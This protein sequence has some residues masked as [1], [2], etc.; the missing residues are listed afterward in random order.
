MEKTILTWLNDI[1]KKACLTTEWF[2]RLVAWAWSG[3]TK[4]LISRYLYITQELW[5]NPGNILC[6]TFTNKAANEMKNR[7]RK[8]LWE[9]TSNSLI[10]TYHGFGVRF[11]REEIHK[12]NY[13]K[14]FKILD[15]EDQKAILREVFKELDIEYKNYTF[16]MVLNEIR[17]IK[18]MPTFSIT[19]DYIKNFWINEK[20]DYT[21]SISKGIASKEFPITVINDI[22]N[23]YFVKQKK[24]FALDFDDLLLFSLYILWTDNITREKRSKKLNYIMIDEYQDSN[25]HDNLLID[26]LSEY[27]KNIFVVGDPD[28]T[29]YEWRGASVW[30]INNFHKSHIKTETIIM[31]ENYRSTKT[32]LS[33]ANS[34]IKNNKNRIEKDLFTKNKE[35]EKIIYFHW[36]DDSDEANRISQKIKELYSNWVK[37]NDIAV[38]FRASASSRKIEQ[39]FIKNN[40]SYIIYGWI[41]FFERKEI[42]DIIAYLQLLM[43]QDDDIAFRRIINYPGRLIWEKRLEYIEQLAN[44]EKTSLYRVL[45]KYWGSKK[46]EGTWSISF[47]DT[48]EY[49]RKQIETIKISDLLDKLLQETWIMKI[50]RQDWDEDRLENVEELISSIIAMEENYWE[51]LALSQYLQDIALYTNLDK[52]EKKGSVK[53]MTIHQAKWL[54]FPYVFICDL[55][56]W[57]FP[58]KRSIEEAKEEWL[59]EERRLMYVATTRAKEQLFLTNSEWFHHSSWD[60][61]PSRFLHEIDNPLLIIEWEKE[62]A[63]DKNRLKNYL[64]KKIWIQNNGRNF[65]IWNNIEHHIFGKWVIE[66]IHYKSKT[67][68]IKFEN[69]N[70]PKAMDIATIEN[71]ITEWKITLQLD[72]PS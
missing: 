49:F 18:H 61:I 59:E 26:I 63:L 21:P 9:D 24:N 51:E 46:F 44:K 64:E 37:L 22:I 65:L 25:T 67:L 34:I 56:E 47:I 42:K 28:Q 68:Y 12:L 13:P 29:I 11:L 48:I 36:K 20:I 6:I 66:D 72:N 32:I 5:I 41:R 23:W 3:K 39:A 16:K 71:L 35:W 70:T 62:S 17:R 53:L 58:N 52:E 14:S 2:I 33:G 50:L 15:E 8:I 60:K 4:A 31:A 40:I 69:R 10:T 1:Q 57:I 19:K 43:N 7:I 27:H 54:E 55:V 38:L 45:K 30:F